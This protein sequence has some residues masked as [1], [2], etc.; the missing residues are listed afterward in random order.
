MQFWKKTM[1]N[2]LRGPIV[3]MRVEGLK[4]ETPLTAGYAPPRSLKH[5]FLCEKQFNKIEKWVFYKK[6]FKT[7]R[8]KIQLTVT[9]K[10]TWQTTVISVERITTY[11]SSRAS[12]WTPLDNFGTMV[13]WY[14]WWCM[15]GRRVR[16]RS[17]CFSPTSWFRGCWRWPLETFWRPCPTSKGNIKTK[18]SELEHTQEYGC[19]RSSSSRAASYSSS[20][21][22]S[23]EN[24]VL[25]TRLKLGR[26]L[27][28]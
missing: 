1:H 24:S 28:L 12:W 21:S 17:I 15:C 4:P 5:N 14:P 13:S 20:S 6:V 23:F 25:D 8:A 11:L 26:G 16:F 7:N 19:N 27:F 10:A 22:C 2:S 9:V 18:I 3:H